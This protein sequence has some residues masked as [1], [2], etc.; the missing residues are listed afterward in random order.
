[1]LYRASFRFFV[2]LFLLSI[3]SIHAQSTSQTARPQTS[4]TLAEML[5]TIAAERKQPLLLEGSP[6]VPSRETVDKARLLFEKRADKPTDTLLA[7]LVLL[8]DYDVQPTGK[9]WLL[10]KRYQ[11]FADFPEVTIAEYAHFLR[12]VGKLVATANPTGNTVDAEL[13]RFDASLTKEQRGL[14]DAPPPPLSPELQKHVEKMKREG[15]D[16]PEPDRFTFVPMARF[17][18]P[19]QQFLQSLLAA[20][21]IG[22]K[23]DNIRRGTS[24]IVEMQRKQTRFFRLSRGERT[25]FANERAAGGRTYQTPLAPTALVFL[26]FGSS[27]VNTNGTQ[28]AEDDSKPTAEDYQQNGE[29]MARVESSPYT[30]TLAVL[31]ERYA[32]WKTPLK[33]NAELEAK[34]V[35]AIALPDDTKTIAE[36][37]ATLFNLRVATSETEIALEYPRPV[38]PNSSMKLQQ[39]IQAIFPAPLLRLC[40]AWTKNGS[41]DFLQQRRT[42]TVSSLSRMSPGMRAR[43]ERDKSIVPQRMGQNIAMKRQ[44]EQAIRRLRVLLEPKIEASK[45]KEVIWADMND[46]ARWLA[47]YVLSSEALPSAYLLSSAAQASSQ[48]PFAEYEVYARR[49]AIDQ[50]RYLQIGLIHPKTRGG[51][52][53]NG[54]IAI[55][56]APRL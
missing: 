53:R 26:N 7:E 35:T 42:R 15:H 20:S 13:A 56:A 22:P 55:D 47:A 49:A 31:S 6:L 38:V 3:S 21:E 27:S 45:R 33:V 48:Q 11:N 41:D 8:Y 2:F 24:M 23:E 14:L 4:T 28:P 9:I 50:Y 5:N 37:L 10:T 40:A 29:P 46:E 32:R 12:T 39:A 17:S 1:M 51:A 52:A 36:S 19:Q 25:F 30:M 34:T 43:I 54:I 16:V 44:R 18:A